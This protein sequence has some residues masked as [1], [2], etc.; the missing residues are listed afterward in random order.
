MATLWVLLVLVYTWTPA[1]PSGGAGEVLPR[2]EAVEQLGPFTTPEM[3]NTAKTVVLLGHH[4]A[5]Y[6]AGLC[7]QQDWAQCT[8]PIS[9][10][11]AF[12]VQTR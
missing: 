5:N 12:C 3:C 2:L 1:L 8:S 10:V 4:W 9:N 6:T 7:A 11:E